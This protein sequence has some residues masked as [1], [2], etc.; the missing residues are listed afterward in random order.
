MCVYR[1]DSGDLPACV[2]ACADAGGG[3]MLF[4][5]LNDPDSEISQRVAQFVTEQIRA[6]LGLDP[7]VR[8][9]SLP[10]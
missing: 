4:G 9:R 6:D 3:A 7:G 2:E 5:D 8:Y 10:S 1:V